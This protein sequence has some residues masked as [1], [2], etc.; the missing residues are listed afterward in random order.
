MQIL[1]MRVIMI[2]MIIIRVRAENMRLRWEIEKQKQDEERYMKLQ[3]EVEHLTSRLH[4]VIS[5]GQ[6]A[7]IETRQ[8]ISLIANLTDARVMIS[9]HRS[10]TRSGPIIARGPRIQS[11]DF[12]RHVAL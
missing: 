1:I 3:Y 2:I 7:V 12:S 4:K 10:H 11:S 8:L 9:H 5:D 6:I